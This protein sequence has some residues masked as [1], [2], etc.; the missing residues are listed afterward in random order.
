M[1]QFNCILNW[2]KYNKNNSIFNKLELFFLILI[3]DGFPECKAGGDG[4][5]IR[6]LL[7][8]FY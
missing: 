7:L 6:A 3:S 1:H 5:S 4:A 8:R 2:C